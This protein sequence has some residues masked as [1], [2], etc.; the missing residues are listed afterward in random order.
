MSEIVRMALIGAGAV[1]D[2]HHVPGIR[3]D[4]RVELVAA[5]P[6]IE[7]PASIAWDGDGKLYVA[8]LNTYSPSGPHGR[9]HLHKGHP[10]S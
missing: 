5:E 3:V 7:E 2:Y 6:M 8:E 10:R 4:P 1:A 9:R